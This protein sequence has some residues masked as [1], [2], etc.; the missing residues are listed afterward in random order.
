M[1]LIGELVP[2]P[3]PAVNVVDAAKS[4][5]AKFDFVVV[6]VILSTDVSIPAEKVEVERSLR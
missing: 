1:P 2:I 3:T 4:P 5:P 6:L